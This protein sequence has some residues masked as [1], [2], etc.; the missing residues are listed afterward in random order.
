[1]NNINLI[2]LFLISSIIYISCNN[3]S[4]DVS[5]GKENSGFT[6][7]SSEFSEGEMIPKKYT[8]DGEDISPPFE[9]EWNTRRN[10]EHCTYCR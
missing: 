2:T 1:M 10:H 6:L 8:C 4:G 3:N 5:A 7:F 9:L